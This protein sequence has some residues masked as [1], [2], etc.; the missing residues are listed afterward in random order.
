MQLT[1][2]ALLAV[3]DGR[4]RYGLIDLYLEALRQPQVLYEA[5][6]APTPK[7]GEG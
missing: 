4:L 2:Q 3:S 5:N 6:A 7:N 1:E